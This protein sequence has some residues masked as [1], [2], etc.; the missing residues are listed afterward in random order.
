MINGSASLAHGAI[1][2]GDAFCDIVP[3]NPGAPQLPKLAAPLLVQTR[4]L[5]HPTRML[6]ISAVTPAILTRVHSLWWKPFHL[7]LDI[8]MDKICCH[9]SPSAYRI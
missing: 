3:T 7:G 8:A 6:R 9:G 1:L 5:I 4:R 2:A